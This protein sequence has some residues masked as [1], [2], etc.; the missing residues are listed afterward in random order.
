MAKTNQKTKQKSKVSFERILE[1]QSK[2][3][4]EE[5]MKEHII[6]VCKS[7]GVSVKSDKKGNLYVSKGEGHT[8]G[9]VCHIDTVHAINPNIDKIQ[10][11]YSTDGD[12]V[13]GFDPDKLAPTGI[14]GD[15]KVGIY[16]ALRCIEKFENIKAAF[17]VEEE[18]GCIGSKN[19]ITSH[20]ENTSFILECDRRGHDDFVNSISGTKMYG[21][22][23]SKDIAPILKEHGYS[24]TTGGLT[25]VLALKSHVDIP[26]ANMSCGYHKPH[27]DNEY[28]VLS[29]VENTMNM[30]FEIME[31]FGDKKYV[32]KAPEPTYTKS[33]V[34]NNKYGHGGYHG[35]S[36][37]TGAYNKPN[38]TAKKERVPL[39]ADEKAILMSALHVQEEKF[40]VDLAK[41]YGFKDD[42]EMYETYIGN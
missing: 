29:Q 21:E 38:T 16:I 36:Y 13:M 12:R 25:D 2:S 5:A 15:D 34:H 30:V 35:G 1:I 26:M 24:E 27:T 9:I 22:E 20:W 23:F 42:I 11:L 33:K 31:Q 19:S 6:N 17:F 28:I 7:L 32:H 4:H 3:T 41:S 39:T 14:G 37:G 8:P 10:L 18:I 40:L